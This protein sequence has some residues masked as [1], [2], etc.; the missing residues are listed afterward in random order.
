MFGIGRKLKHLAANH[1]R[2]LLFFLFL[3]FG[4]TGKH[5]ARCGLAFIADTIRPILVC[6][7]EI[8]LFSLAVIVR[9]TERG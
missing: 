6:A 5:V 7:T 8:K 4:T 1:A 9:S 2:L 3:T